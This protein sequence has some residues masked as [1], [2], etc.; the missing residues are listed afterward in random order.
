MPWQECTTM[1]ERQE[2]IAFARQEDAN[3]A[4]LCRQFGIS[5]KTAYKWL[6]RAAAGE[7][8]GADRSRRPHTS[9]RIPPPAV[10]GGGAGL[11]PEEPARG[12]GGAGAAPGES[13]LGW[14]QA[15]PRPGA[16][17]HGAA[18]RTEH[19]HRHPASPRPAPT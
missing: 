13:G 2:F 17:G 10:E 16:P 14:A 4:A 12:G 6:A 5:R 11:R 18:S 9:P 1:S 8:D 3:I 19:H 15:A 7:T